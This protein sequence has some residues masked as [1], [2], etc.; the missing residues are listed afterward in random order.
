MH[1][2]LVAFD[3]PA[4]A[5]AF[6]SEIRRRADSL[7]WD[8]RVRRADGRRVVVVPERVWRREAFVRSVAERYGGTIRDDDRSR[9]RSGQRLA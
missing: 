3:A 2:V 8:V 7:L 5:Y 4:D 9:D 1:S 6:V